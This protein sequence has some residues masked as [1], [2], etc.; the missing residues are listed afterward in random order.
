[1]TEFVMTRAE[2]LQSIY[3]DMYKDA[4]GV[5]PRWVDTSGWSEA[6]FTREFESLQGTIDRNAL[7]EMENQKVA[8]ALFEKRVA[9]TI[10]AG[11]GDYETAMRWIHEA[12]NTNGDNQYLCWTLGLPYS[13]LR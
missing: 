9:D 6:D 8:V 10:A 1:M 13:Y 7:Q 3:W 2:E 11:A 5:R 12:E 4:H